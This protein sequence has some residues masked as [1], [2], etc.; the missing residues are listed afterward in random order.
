MFLTFIFNIFSSFDINFLI[1]IFCN[2][3]L[4][5]DFHKIYVRTLFKFNL[6]SII[7][8]I[9]WCKVILQADLNTY[10]IRSPNEVQNPDNITLFFPPSLFVSKDTPNRRENLADTSEPRAPQFKHFPIS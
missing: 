3:K 8:S 9:P 4:Q 2:I 7:Y 6:I 1:Y 10:F 5:I